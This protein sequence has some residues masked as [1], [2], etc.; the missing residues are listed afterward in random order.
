MIKYYCDG[1][2]KEVKTNLIAERLHI[3][4]KIGNNEFEV[5]IMVAK[6]DVWNAGIICEECLRKVLTG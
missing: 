6:N 4:R 2:E 3:K 5:E 1:C